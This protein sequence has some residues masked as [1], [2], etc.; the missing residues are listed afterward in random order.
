MEALRVLASIFLL[1]G[2]ALFVAAEYALVGSRRGRVEAMG[3]RGKKNAK[4]LAKALEDISPYVAATQIGITMLG[5]AIGA[6]TEPYVAGVLSSWLTML[7]PNVVRVLSYLIVVF[8]LLVV[9]E[10]CPKYLALR[11]ADRVALFMYRPLVVI[12][13]VLRP[14]IWLAQSMAGMLLK[15]LKVDIHQSDKDAIP[16]EELLMLVQIGGASGMLD[17]LQADMVSRALRLDVLDARDIMIHRLDIKWLDASIT[18]ADLLAR[19]KDIPY[20][21]MPVCRG[22]ID[23]MI[24]VAYLHDIVKHLDD[25]DFSLEKIVRQVIAVPENLTMAKILEMIRLEKTQM[26]IVSDEYGG[27]SGL[28]TLEDV[29]EE[30]FGDLEDRLESDRK[31][32]EEHPGGRV[33]ARATVRIDEL[34]AQLKLDID[35]GENTDTLATIVVNALGRV[36][37]T[38][39]SVMTNVGLI[40]VENMARRRITRVSL[41]LPPDLS[42][43]QAS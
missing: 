37:R 30:V 23:D 14:I 12:V 11:Y 8:V 4:G 34:V 42:R 5:I 33:S 35:I 25:E 20:S 21:R 43:L 9:G 22:D 40:R 39:D 16:K 19:L 1:L 31:P 26:L 38:G 18:K 28:V 2:S 36:P 41:Q 32:I 13:A 24:G 17:K 29:V 27:T 3:R 10:L 6:F 7:D 15:P